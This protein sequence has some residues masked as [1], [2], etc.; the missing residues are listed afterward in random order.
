MLR[1]RFRCF[2]P[3]RCFNPKVIQAPPWNLDELRNNWRDS[4]FPVAELQ[5][6][7]EHDNQEKRQKL[8]DLLSDE[9]FIPGIKYCPRQ[10]GCGIQINFETDFFRI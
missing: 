6:F 5:D 7:T 4:D 8:R 3:V 2:N 9:I 10:S 1:S